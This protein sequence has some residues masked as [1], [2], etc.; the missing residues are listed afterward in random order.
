MLK[1]MEQS[2]LNKLAVQATLHCLTGCAIGEVLGAVIGSALNWNNMATALLAVL[3]AFLFGY[4]FTIRPL[5]RHGMSLRAAG[6]VALAADTLS[7]A[8]MEI[9]DT[10]IILSVPGALEA[11]PTTLL[12]WGSL[13]FALAVAFCVAVPVNRALIA[14]GKGHALVHSHHDQN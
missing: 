1:D 5:L 7:I 4:S 9:V 2:K 8:T 3:L 14:R 6:K 13:A 11:G 10:L 12:F